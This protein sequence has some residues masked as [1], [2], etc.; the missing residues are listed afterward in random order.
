M[1]QKALFI[2]LSF[3]SLIYSTSFWY[4]G[5]SKDYDTKSFI[6]L[7]TFSFTYFFSISLWYVGV[8]ENMKQKALSFCL[9]F[10]FTYSLNFPLICWRLKKYDRNGFFSLF[11]FLFDFTLI[12]GRWK[13]MIKKLGITVSHHICG[14]ILELSGFRGHLRR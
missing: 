6:P 1:I 14:L 4:A 9:L 11:S 12:C 10:S 5:V 3:H 8:L 2:C 7:F 13:I